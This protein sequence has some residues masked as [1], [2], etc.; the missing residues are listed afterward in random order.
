MARCGN[1]KVRL[2]DYAQ[3]ELR[4]PY[5]KAKKIYSKSN[6]RRYGAGSAIHHC[7]C[8]SG[9]LACTS[10]LAQHTRLPSK[11]RTDAQRQPARERRAD[12][13]GV[14]EDIAPAL[15]VPEAALRPVWCG[16]CRA[17]IRFPVGHGCSFASVLGRYTEVGRRTLSAVAWS[18]RVACEHKQPTAAL[19]F[20][21]DM[22]H[23]ATTGASCLDIYVCARARVCACA[24]RPI[25]GHTLL[26]HS[27]AHRRR[28]EVRRRPQRPRP[29]PRLLPETPER[30]CR[31][32]RI[33]E[34]WAKHRA[35]HQCATTCSRLPLHVA[36]ASWCTCCDIIHAV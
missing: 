3:H 8:C 7:T 33:T 12:G 23:R 26:R 34:A 25:D 32:H 9:R 6:A 31:L 24:P 21:H 4:L 16:R 18:P 36:C 30:S 20:A 1:R 10:A 19:M 29:R 27:G 14:E 11:G 13:V 35:R 22:T 5:Y 15:F 28:T 2:R 17:N